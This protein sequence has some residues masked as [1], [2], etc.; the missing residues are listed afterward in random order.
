MTETHASYETDGGCR[1][2][3]R[4]PF[5]DPS[6]EPPEP[7]DIRAILREAGLTGSQVGRL[8]G[9]DGRTVRKW[10]GGERRIPYSAWRLLLVECGK[11]LKGRPA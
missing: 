3:C 11:A 8:V 4:L 1:R 6:Y 7:D 5:A 9:V 10:T 2:N